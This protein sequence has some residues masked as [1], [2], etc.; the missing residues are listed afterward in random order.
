M[1]NKIILLKYLCAIAI[2]FC[3]ML[4]YFFCQ[5]QNTSPAAFPSTGRMNYTRAWTATAPDASATHLLTRSVTDV[6]QVTEYFDGFGR[7][8]Q[9]VSK[10]ITPSGNDLVAAN[11][12]DATTSN[13]IYR[14]NPFA[15]TSPATGDQAGDGNFKLDRFHEQ[16]AFYNGYL[17]NQP[18]ETT[19]SS[20][21]PNWAYS[22]TIYESSPV[23]RVL[24]N[25]SPGVSWVGSEGVS[26]H[27]T[28]L[29]Y[30]VNSASD[31]VVMWTATTNKSTTN[32]FS[33]SPALPTYQGIY[34]A[35][36]L[37][38]SILTD[39]SGHQVIEYKDQYGQLVL[40]KV[41]NTAAADN[42][43]GS[44][45]AGFLCTYY[46]YDDY[47][48]LRFVITPN[49]V[50]LIDGN[51]GT[52]SQSQI[53]ELCYYFEYDNQNRAVVRKNP[54]T[55]GG[56]IGEQWMV[57]DQ[58][59][60]LVMQQD[61]YQR[62]NQI[63]KFF[64]YDPLDRIITTGFITDPSSNLTNY[65][66][67]IA[68]VNS[69]S[70]SIAYPII[71]NYSNETLSQSFYD[72]YNWMNATNS[73]TLAA[74]INNSS[75]DG[76]ANGNFIAAN[77]A[78]PPY[79]QT[80][81]QSAMTRGML[82]GTR[83]E[84]LG[85]NGGQ[86]IYNVDF[87]DARGR[88]IQAQT[89]N[90]SGGTDISTNQYDWSGK[91]L[92][93]L[94]SQTLASASNP[95][96]HRVASI[97][98]YDAGG[99]L[100]TI[101][102]VINSTING[103]TV[104]AN[105]LVETNV[106]DELGMLQKRTF[107]NN[108]ESMNYDYNVRGWTL[109]ANR[110]FAKTALS[111]TNYFGFDLGYDQSTMAPGGGSS[112]GSYATPSFTGTIAGTAWKSKSDGVLRKFDYTYDNPR[113][114]I[115][116]PYNESATVNTWGNAVLNFSVGGLSYDNNGNLGQAQR[117]G[118]M[119]GGSQL[120]DDLSY[121]YN[122]GKDATT[123]ANFSN[124][125]QNV[126]DNAN[127]AQSALGDL[128]YPASPGK[129][130]SSTDYGYDAN[131][132]I[133]S[134]YNRN[135]SAV[136]YQYD[137]NLSNLITVPGKGTIQYTYDA[138]GNKLQKQSIENNV[139]V[140]Y[141]GNNYTTNITTTTKYIDGFIYKSV[142]YSNASLSSLNAGNTDVLV[143]FGHEQGRVRYVPGSNPK[144]VFDY[145]MRDHLGSVRMVLTD[146]SQ[147]DIYPPTSVETSTQTVN[148][149]TSSPSAFESQYYNIIPAN[150]TP[151][152]PLSWWSGVTNN[153]YV[154]AN[155]SVPVNDPY[156]TNPTTTASANIY[157]LSGWNGTTGNKTGLAITLKVMAGDIVNIYGK[158]VW[159][160]TTT[161]ATYQPIT[162]SLLD[163]FTALAA[164]QPVAALH[165][166]VTAASLNGATATT[167]P[168][169]TMLNGTQDQTSNTTYAPKAAINWILFD[170]QFRPVANSI[171][172]SLVSS[173]SDVVN[174]HSTGN[175][176]IP[177]N[178]NMPKSGYLYVYCSNESNIDVYFD[179]LQVTLKHGPIE[180]ETHYYP[181]G[182]TMNGIS[183]KAWGKTDNNFHFQGNE[184]QNHEWYDGTGLEEYDFNARYYD[185]QLGIWHNQDPITNQA[186]PYSAMANNPAMYN[187]ANGK[188][189]ICIVLIA[190]A[191][192]G[193]YSGASIES[194]GH[195]NPGKW[196]SDWWK[197]A[198]AGAIIA[199]GAVIGA[200]EVLSPA[201]GAG[202]GAS[203]WSLAL[204]AAEGVGQNLI[205]TGVT[206]LEL[207][208]SLTAD[209]LLSASVTGAISGA[210]QSSSVQDFFDH[211]WDWADNGKL[212]DLYKG[213]TSNIVGGALSTAAKDGIGGSD[214]KTFL[215]DEYV[216][217]FTQAAGQITHNAF[218]S[219][220]KDNK[221]DR[222]V[223]NSASAISQSL[224]ND[225]LNHASFGNF[226]P[227][228]GTGTF[229]GSIF[230]SN[231]LP[232]AFFG[233]NAD[234][235]SARK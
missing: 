2:G 50:Q 162:S 167:T 164:S 156:A 32:Q 23:A 165:G 97:V 216:S 38:K 214:W 96:T 213:A 85:T 143:A 196:N 146:E 71:S 119:V 91:L 222:V 147:T 99:R 86:S 11:I 207:Q 182:L 44:A 41:Q 220:L 204:S 205:M 190:A 139:S 81:T 78:A 177:T 212:P 121:N 128:H 48:N 75:T 25:F 94:V 70:S 235:L 224:V 152:S 136:S 42:G 232:T 227:D 100:T 153:S 223:Y 183:D 84:V 151:V 57:Y 56:V 69:A 58:R 180:E 65:N 125:L 157:K 115:S 80:I 17:N 234:N 210:F 127:N 45:H 63:W 61:G 62:A 31:N 35:N 16:V 28:Q 225:F 37:I 198:V 168:L 150:I 110:D 27:N 185:Q 116:A 82:V 159:H 9:T 181:Y 112:V 46:V 54:G 141:N 135:I 14:Y 109:G 1:L 5:A 53:D 101:S 33:T 130:V 149:V 228:Q 197:G 189:P 129:T 8:T 24:S 145:F 20:S 90:S 131:G 155:A 92:V 51:W 93:N 117:Y 195:W 52:I 175:N 95:Q 202:M 219:W 140:L 87:Y 105:S 103:T 10:Q 221:L 200:T 34:G 123:G 171:G 233:W 186:S 133:T 89:I 118:F 137:L 206:D 194:G 229:T 30:L 215:N 6:K 178:I 193:A 226:N 166:G 173:T 154:D 68:H 199:D 59:G 144:F 55:P 191:V 231:L 36:T 4:N 40:K 77:N 170:D 74:A 132:N 124:R 7:P 163:F 106:Y 201:F 67:L 79:A 64:Q 148:G 120:I 107:G 13:E 102:K 161:T 126:T 208:Q 15:V 3:I 98:N 174:D 113:R 19:T 83:L 72:N 230:W 209:Q 138:G 176:A 18:G 192:V 49:V 66:D 60:R 218:N 73:S 43:T 88:L 76:T 104:T 187:D 160:N 12:Y 21:V 217:A 47:G 142:N 134:D 22:K 184:M 39:E 122:I 26:N 203:A 211:A 179:N 172:T 29:G 108:L 158:S 111:T 114:L 188:C 169:T